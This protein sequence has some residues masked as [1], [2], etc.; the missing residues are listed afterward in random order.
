MKHSL[1]FYINGKWVTPTDHNR[2]DVINPATEKPVGAISVGNANDID[3]AVQAAR[4]AFPTWSK[5]TRNERLA[6]LGQILAEYERRY[7]DMAA[8]I[9][10]EMGAP[11]NTSKDIQAAMGRTHV[12]AAIT[13]LETFEFSTD[14]GP[15]R[16]VKEAI[17]VCGFITPWNWPINQV[18]SKV[19]PAIATGCVMILKPSEIAPFSSIVWAEIMEAAG[20]PAGVFNLVNGD[21]PGAGAALSCHPDVD[22]IS[23]TGSTR[24]GVEVAKNAAPTVKRVHQE[25]GGKSANIL[26]PDADF[27]VAVEHCVR[28]VTLNSGQNCNAPTRLL[29][30]KDKMQDVEA[31]ALAVIE[32]VSVGHPDNDIDMGPVVSKIQWDKIQGLIKQGIQEGAHLVCGGLGLPEGLTAGYFVK[33]TIFSRANNQM[34]IAREEIFGP[35]LTIIGYA[36]VEEAVEIANDTPYGLASY[37]SG[38]DQDLVQQIASD[39]RS[40]QVV[41]NCA[42]PDPMAPFGGYKQSGNGRE[43]GDFAFEEFLEIKAVLGFGKA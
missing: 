22:M 23:F 1:D 14:R 8:A 10:L 39:L 11:K 16:I 43:W 18:A 32:T 31:I 6:L 7:D 30:P 5:S 19:A 38:R 37:V 41:I 12:E 28:A 25:L 2:I 13:A 17:G 20:T 3:Q 24:A 27:D 15:T 29:V 35:V 36:S 4:A 26:L 34:Q 42:A 33:P 9:T 21:G 40:G